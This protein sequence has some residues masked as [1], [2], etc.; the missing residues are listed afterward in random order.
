MCLYLPLRWRN[1]LNLAAKL[2]W[3]IQI[4]F[5]M[6]VIVL[7]LKNNMMHKQYHKDTKCNL[8]HCY[9]LKTHYHYVKFRWYFLMIW[10][11]VY[12]FI[13]HIILKIL[14]QHFKV[15]V[16][17]ITLSSKAKHLENIVLRWWYIVDRPLVVKD[18]INYWLVKY[19]K[20][21]L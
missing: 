18:I 21:T 14:S 8:P 9:H 3:K 4:M 17:P 15:Y 16:V 7:H 6:I 20:K 12:P 13:G 5:R 19:N 11:C 2:H 10:P 1:T